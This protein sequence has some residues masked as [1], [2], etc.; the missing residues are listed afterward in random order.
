MS[1]PAAF[2]GVVL[3]WATTP[4]AIKWSSVGAGFLFGVSARMLLGVFVCL[5]LIAVLSRQMRWH[6]RASA[7]YLV[8]GLGIYGAMTMVYWGAQFIPSGM[9]SVLFGLTPVVT[10]LMA[11]LWLDEQVF[12]PFRTLGMLLGLAGTALLFFDGLHAGGLAAWGVLAVLLSVTLH[13]LSSVWVKRIGA[14]LH[15]L[16]TTTGA[17]L[18]AVPLYLGTWVTTD[19]RLPQVV[20]MRALWSILYLGVI[21]TALGFVLYYYVLREVAA[22]RVAMITLVTPLLALLIGYLFNAEQ[23]GSAQWLGTAV[24][25][26]GLASY[27]WG[28]ALLRARSGTVSG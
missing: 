16:E 9:I 15:P 17:L 23:P 4:L 18:I 12:S 6:A 20:D 7:T 3:I 26:I 21:A 1:V 28:D 13:S 19:G 14:G 5:V 25:L 2:V 27:Q 10:G 22:S 24:T 8:A 11:A